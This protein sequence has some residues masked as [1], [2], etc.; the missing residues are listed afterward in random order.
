MMNLP[1][2]GQ[3]SNQ[4]QNHGIKK[5]LVLSAIILIIIY[6]IAGLD[7]GRFQWSPGFHWIINALGAVLIL[8]GEIIFLIAQKQKKSFEIS[9]FYN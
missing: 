1:G 8:I 6:I 4:E 3:Q 2:N 7:S 5:I 9:L